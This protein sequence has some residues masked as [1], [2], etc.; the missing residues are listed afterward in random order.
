MWFSSKI[1]DCIKDLIDYD[2]IKDCCKC[3]NISM[4]SNFHRNENKND[5]L[6]N[7]GRSCK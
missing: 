4:K 7:K 2:S 1:S 6:Y 3:G 5:G